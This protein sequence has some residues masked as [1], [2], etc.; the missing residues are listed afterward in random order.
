[1][2]NFIPAASFRFLTP[3][4][5]ALAAV[6]GAGPRFKRRVAAAANLDQGSRRILDLGCGTGHLVQALTRQ[7]PSSRVTGLDID[8]DILSLAHRRL[9][10]RLAGTGV[11][12]CGSADALPFA[13]ATMDAALSTLMLH[14]CHS[15]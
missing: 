13:D 6:L 14:H 2:A 11:L 8:R 12:V 1:M 4:Y 9:E 5:D 7:Y 15:T 10:R 3:P